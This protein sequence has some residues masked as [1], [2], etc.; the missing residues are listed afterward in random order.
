MSPILVGSAEIALYRARRQE[1]SQRSPG[2]SSCRPARRRRRRGRT[3]SGHRA[4]QHPTTPRWRM[5]ATGCAAN[6]QRIGGRPPSTPCHT[7]P[8][9]FRTQMR[10][11]HKPAQ[12]EGEGCFPL[13]PMRP[14]VR[15]AP[16]TYGTPTSTAHRSA[17]ASRRITFVGSS[18][19]AEAWRRTLVG[20]EGPDRR[21]WSRRPRGRRRSG[22]SSNRP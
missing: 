10:P 21:S 6:R 3:A 5:P 16:S 9:S 8:S 1:S 2:R 11:C 18:L 15:D 19:P 20:A 12:T 14:V 13:I 4:A 7:P 22:T 17:S